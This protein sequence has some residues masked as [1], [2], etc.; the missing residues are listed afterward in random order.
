MNVFFPVEILSQRLNRNLA[1]AVLALLLLLPSFVAMAEKTDRE[2]PIHLEADSAKVDDLNKV[3]VFEGNVTLVQGT[4]TIRSDRM[5]VKQDEQGFNS[6]TAFGKPASFRQKREGFDEYVEGFGDRIE[7]EA[8]SDRMDLFTKAMVKRG[9][10]EVRGDYITYNAGTELFKVMGGGKNA[11]TS[12]NTNGRVRAIIQPKAKES[13]GNTTKPSP[14]I[15]K[16]AE[17]IVSPRD[18]FAAPR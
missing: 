15:L 10:D 3:S 1:N 4:L 13:T 12:T 9:N 16:G 17:Q 6:G 14:V 5:V 7:Y 8:K 11:A 2:K 18:D